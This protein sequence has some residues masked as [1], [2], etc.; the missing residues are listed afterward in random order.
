MLVLQPQHSLYR[1]LT[2]PQESRG[3]N[4]V[5]SQSEVVLSHGWRGRGQGING[6]SVKY[7]ANTGQHV[8]DPQL[9][10]SVSKK[11]CLLRMAELGWLFRKVSAAA[12]PRSLQEQ[13]L[14]RQA[15][16]FVLQVRH[17]C[18]GA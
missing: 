12:E 1:R 4:L 6:K 2:L 8:L 17:R 10:I 18:P 15:F 7:E 3:D 9:S 16:C 13:G 14:V 11:D 5:A